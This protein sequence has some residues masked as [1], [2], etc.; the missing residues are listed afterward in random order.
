MLTVKPRRKLATLPS[1]GI[2][3]NYTPFTGCR[4]ESLPHCHLL[5]FS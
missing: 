3:M 5:A 2:F 1:V 4:G